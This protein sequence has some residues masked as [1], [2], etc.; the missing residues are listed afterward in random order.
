MS[1]FLLVYVNLADTA[2][3]WSRRVEITAYFENEVRP[4]EIASLKSKI[5]AVPGTNKVS[6]VDKQE[7]IKRFRSRLKGQESLLEGVAADVLPAS[8][9]IVLKRDF[10]TT[11]AIE[12]YVAALRKIPG[13]TEVQYGEE[14]VRRFNSFM[15]F[16]RFVGLLIGGF[17]VVAVVFIVANTI[18]LTVLARKDELEILG[19]VGATPFFIKAPFLLEGLT[20]GAVGSLLSLAISLATYYSILYNAGNFLSF[21]PATA[22]LSFLPVPYC[23]G[24]VVAGVVLGFIGSIASLRR[25]INI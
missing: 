22:G 20:Q 6:Y 19:L 5:L 25:L 14:W 10:R 7:A 9:E 8:L 21:N 4:L 16:M 15:Q 2:E 17:L 18:K 13:I 24:I 1:L 3:E 23:A 12:K 11:E